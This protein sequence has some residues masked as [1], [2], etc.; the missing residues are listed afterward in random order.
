MKKL[1]LNMLVYGALCC[2]CTKVD[3]TLGENLVPSSQLQPLRIDTMRGW[4]QI[5]AKPLDSL[6]TANFTYAA[7]GIYN[8]PRFGTTKAGFAA[9]FE[10]IT[11]AAQTYFGSDVDLT[12]VEFDSLRLEILFSGTF[13][14]D[15]YY[16]S[17]DITPNEYSMQVKIYE[18]RQ[19]LKDSAVYYGASGNDGANPI[20]S[21]IDRDNPI[22]VIEKKINPLDTF[23]TITLN[24][25][26]LK[27]RLQNALSLT[28]QEDFV[29]TFKG[30][31]IT[32]EGSKGCIKY[33][34]PVYSYSASTGAYS[35]NAGL[36]AYGRRPSG[37]TTLN[38]TFGYIIYS[39]APRF[40]VYEHERSMSSG[41]DADLY[42]QGLYG[43]GVEVK[44]NADS[45]QAWKKDKSINRVELQFGI[46]NEAVHAPSMLDMFPS[47]VS[48][49]CK[50][51]G[52]YSVI[53]DVSVG[54]FD[55]YINRSLMRYS[56]NV[57]QFFGDVY[58]GRTDAMLILPA[59]YYSAMSYGVLQREPLMIVT[60][61][62]LGK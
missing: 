23:F 16:D 4:V 30:L 19:T 3:N 48:A 47:Q 26:G 39:A 43:M 40:A 42:M 60:Y 7:L 17:M 14:G 62:D 55:G 53:R 11:Y 59:A 38:T 15:R 31:Y 28:A 33:T 24:D 22:A 5:S 20:Y 35:A 37:D 6:S 54:T 21:F 36:W 45:I 32:V 61:G 18:L 49:I 10:P 8:D 29:N 9:Q 58:K 41:S 46:A 12:K 56:A 50:Y 27:T 44:I 51:D 2:A 52:A 25:D 1:L 13:Y 34:S 57:T